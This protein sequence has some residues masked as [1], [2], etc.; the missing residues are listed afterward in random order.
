MLPVEKKCIFCGEKPVEKNKEHVLPKWLLELSG[1]PKRVVNQGI[2]WKTGNNRFFSADQFVF[3]ACTDCNSFYA[4]YLESD[5][6]RIIE[7]LIRH[8]PVKCADYK[9]LLDWFDKVRVGL[10]LGFRY[11]NKNHLGIKPNFHIDQRLG[12]KDRILV[13]YPYNKGEKGITYIGTDSPLF[14][15]MPSTLGIRINN[16]IFINVS[17][18]YLV[19]SRLGFP[20]PRVSEIK[21]EDNNM[22]SIGEFRKK[23]RV[24][25][26]V[27]PFKFHKP[28]IYIAQAKTTWD[29]FQFTQQMYSRPPALGN[30]YINNKDIGSNIFDVLASKFR[31]DEEFIELGEIKLK[32]ARMA[33]LLFLQVFEL[34]EYLKENAFFKQ[35]LPREF[36]DLHNHI[37]KLYKNQY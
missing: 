17:S 27:F 21:K 3:P 30:Y 19:S 1:D 7:K 8:E 33:W 16:L 22:F 36:V 12:T 15:V 14:S 6:K 9:I 4:D 35:E 28:F 13:C 32:E 11:L 37:K 2:D 25:H 18:D 24:T 31:Y 34:Q 23:D 20:Y 29:I 10:W 5:A 26:P